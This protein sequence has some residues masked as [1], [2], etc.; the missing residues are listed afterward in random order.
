M[1]R[2]GGGA[3]A[4]SGTDSSSAAWVGRW[5]TSRWRCRPGSG[6]GGGVMELSSN[7][8][9]RAPS[10]D[11]SWREEHMTTKTLQSSLYLKILLLI[12]L[13]LT[14]WWGWSCGSHQETLKILSG[15]LVGDVFC[16]EC[17]VRRMTYLTHNSLIHKCIV[18]TDSVNWS[19]LK[20]L[21]RGI[22]TIELP[23]MHNSVHNMVLKG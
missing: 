10:G 4:S 22:F 15:L 20:W 2:G 14:T 23:A 1:G 9:T 8:A 6:I 17:V 21:S 19:D 18:I 11:A 3:T 5:T 16:V 7:Q 13:L 12:I